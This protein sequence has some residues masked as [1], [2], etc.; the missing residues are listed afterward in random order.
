M[1]EALM[2][3]LKN[4]EYDMEDSEELSR[5]KSFGILLQ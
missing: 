1:K 3:E 5:R 2:N 4:E